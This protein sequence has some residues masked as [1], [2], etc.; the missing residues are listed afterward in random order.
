MEVVQY[1]WKLWLRKAGE[2]RATLPRFK[3]QLLNLKGG[4]FRQIT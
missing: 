2:T 4:D 3:S 1:D